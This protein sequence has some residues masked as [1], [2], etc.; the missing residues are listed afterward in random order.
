MLSVMRIRHWLGFETPMSANKMNDFE[1]DCG[2]QATLAT[3][4]LLCKF[5]CMESRLAGTS[6]A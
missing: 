2:K 6:R 1:K 4:G 5:Y 3:R